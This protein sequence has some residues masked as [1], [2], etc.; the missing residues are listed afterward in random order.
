MEITE[1]AK[2]L[3]DL[4][5]DK[6]AEKLLRKGEGKKKLMT[7]VSDYKYATQDDINDFNEEMKKCGKR[8]AIVKISDYTQLPPN[9]VLESLK[10]AQEKKC[11]DD[12]HIAYIEKV[13]DPILFGKINGFENLYFYIDQWG[14]DVKIEDIIGAE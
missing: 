10:K 14:D 8:L 12:F 7:A 6:I 13:K 9:S 5:M 11:F 2:L 3:K 1:K 4:G